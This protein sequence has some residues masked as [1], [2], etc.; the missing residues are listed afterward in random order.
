MFKLILISCL[1]LTLSRQ[2][3]IVGHEQVSHAFLFRR[4]FALKLLK[5][6]ITNQ[7]FNSVLKAVI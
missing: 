1:V 5:R 4:M 2:H 3:V 7:I 6:K